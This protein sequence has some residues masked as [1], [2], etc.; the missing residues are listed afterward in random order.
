MRPEFLSNLKGSLTRAQLFQK[1]YDRHAEHLQ[2]GICRKGINSEQLFTCSRQR[3]PCL[4]C[5]QL[6]LGPSPCLFSHANQVVSP[7][8][9]DGPLP[10]PAE[11]GHPV[12]HRHHLSERMT[13]GRRNP[14]HRHD[15]SERMTRGTQ[16]PEHRA[17]FIRE[18]D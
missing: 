6:A 7:L 3:R 14:E 12:G 1:Q 9:T 13:R 4:P 16:H 18:N 10:S 17:Q 15:L 5:N 8:Y 11:A 2:S